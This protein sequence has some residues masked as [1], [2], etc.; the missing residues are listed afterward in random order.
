M[1]LRISSASLLTACL[2]LAGCS[3][4]K[5]AAVSADEPVPTS[6]PTGDTVPAG[7]RG[8]AA[9]GDGTVPVVT[10]EFNQPPE[11]QLPTQPVESGT[12][13]TPITGDGRAVGPEDRIVAN[14]GVYDLSSGEVLA[15]SWADGIPLLFV[16]NDQEAPA[17]LLG[18][19]VGVTVGSRYWTVA[20]RDDA[21]VGGSDDPAV[22][23]NQVLMVVDVVDAQPVNATVSGAASPVPAGYP[24]V[25]GGDGIKPTLSKPTGPVPAGPERVPVIVGSGP[26]IASMSQTILQY[27]M[28][29]WATGTEVDSSWDTLG[30]PL[31]W[32][33]GLGKLPP[34]VENQL[35]NITEGSRVMIVLPPTPAEQLAPGLDPS[36]TYVVLIDVLAVMPTA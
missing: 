36:K 33:E 2:L 13:D 14:L 31:F 16:L 26:A 18:G 4:A 3:D 9:R 7:D 28:V 25:S 15:T 12:S 30:G 24:E 17:A 1:S 20:T 11:V 6:V 29:E 21:V 35:Q 23:G 5:D 8:V 22:A 19:L 27:V 10:G 34:V 32:M